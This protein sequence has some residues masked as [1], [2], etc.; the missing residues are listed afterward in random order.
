[1]L[2]FL[3]RIRKSQF[4]SGKTRKYL[5]YAIGE[6]VLV[7]IGILLAIQINTWYQSKKNKVEEKKMIERIDA[8]LKSDAQYLLN[9]DS[10]MK[11]LF[12]ILKE[13][14]S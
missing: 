3:R 11:E 2:T 8:E 1:M 4:G 14:F 7:V 13:S 5:L 10:N 12:L 6:I 9:I